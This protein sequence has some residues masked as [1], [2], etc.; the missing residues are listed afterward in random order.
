VLVNIFAF[1]QMPAFEDLAKQPL[2]LLLAGGALGA[3][4]LSAN[5]FL[6]PRIGAGALLCFV[7]AGQ[8]VGALAID[9][10]GLFGPALRELT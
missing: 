1:R 3:A 7:V 8:L 10:F 9:R 6:A 4:Y 5:V 2:Y